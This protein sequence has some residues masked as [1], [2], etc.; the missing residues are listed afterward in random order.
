MIGV[1]RLGWATLAGVTHNL[2]SQSSCLT[3]NWGRSKL[4]DPGWLQFWGVR[5]AWGPQGCGALHDKYC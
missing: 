1:T 4:G 3:S 5:E 2:E